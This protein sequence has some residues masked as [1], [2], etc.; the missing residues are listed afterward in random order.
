[1]WGIVLVLLLAMNISAT[2]QGSITL[3]LCTSQETVSGAR[4]VLYSVGKLSEDGTLL[5]SDPFPTG[6]MPRE[7]WSAPETAQ[8][9]WKYSYDQ[10]LNGRSCLTD[11]NGNAVFAD[12]QDG[13][14]LLGQ[15]EA[16]GGYQAFLPFLV[17]LPVEIGGESN[18]NV[19]AKPKITPE[20]S[21]KTA[22]GIAVLPAFLLGCAGIGMNILLYRSRK[23]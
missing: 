19:Q 10:G 18:R 5:L 15:A 16:A 4:I 17:R 20:E 22:D 9:L 2:E 13:V 8:M 12:L 14:Y 1:M 7:V 3:S 6:S 21:P 23:E 11:E